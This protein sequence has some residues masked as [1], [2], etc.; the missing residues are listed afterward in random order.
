MRPTPEVRGAISSKIQGHHRPIDASKL[1]N[2]I[3]L[4][5]KVDE[6][7]PFHD[8]HLHR[9]RA[10]AQPPYRS[11]DYSTPLSG[12]CV[13]YLTLLEPSAQTG[14]RGLIGRQGARGLAMGPAAG[15][16]FVAERLRGP[17]TR[18]MS[19]V[20]ALAFVPSPMIR[21]WNRRGRMDRA[22]AE[23]LAPRGRLPRTSA[24]LHSNT[25]LTRASRVDGTS[26]PSIFAVLRLIVN[27][28][29]LGSWTGRSAGFAPR[30][31]R[32]T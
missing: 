15:G 13:R 30:K 32:S 16:G 24:R 21:R 22:A 27:S 26:R 5:E 28:N 10:D 2:W 29:L 6:I 23:L 18:S 19:A 25:S 4:P 9:E 17:P 31:M 7:P 3:T 11:M 14:V 1:V 8:S 20:I 12:R